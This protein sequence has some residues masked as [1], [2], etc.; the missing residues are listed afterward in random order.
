LAS[1]GRHDDRAFVL[2]FQ[3]NQ[4]HSE[5][6]ANEDSGIAIMN[7][8]VSAVDLDCCAAGIKFVRTKAVR[9]GA[10]CGIGPHPYCNEQVSSY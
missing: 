2:R 8:N 9:K 1:G 4:F 7:E 5:S 10:G 3:R 6:S